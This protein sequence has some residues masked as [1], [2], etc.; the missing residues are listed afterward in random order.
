MDTSTRKS[1]PG[2][3]TLTSTDETGQPAPIS[4]DTYEEL[5]HYFKYAS[6]AYSPVCLRPN[7]NT[8]VLQFGN[9]LSDV[10]G[11]IAR[12]DNRR[13]IVVALRG[14]ASATDV[15]LDAQILLVPFLTPG[16]NLPPKARVHAGFLTAWNSVAAE[17]SATLALQIKLHPTH[18][19]VVLGHSMGG[20]I[21]TLAA[22]AFS[23]LFHSTTDT[24]HL[25]T[26]GAPR[27][28]YVNAQLAERA[29]PTVIPTSLGYHHHGIEYWQHADP[30][31]PETTL[32]CACDGED[33]Q[34]S[35]RIPS[36]GV[37]PAHATYFGIM[38]PT[39][40]CM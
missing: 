39:P 24:L 20:A 35:A 9:Y 15:L 18:R 37:T 17:I 14:S 13:E 5:V 31:A 3:S 19:L 38:V 23:Q 8:L 6:S 25:F 11:F 36:G 22:V 16:V 27:T 21:A 30:P 32:R 33:P 34:C 26:Y 2:A 10:Q 7:G 12:D 40:F 28:G 4:S 1:S 29:V